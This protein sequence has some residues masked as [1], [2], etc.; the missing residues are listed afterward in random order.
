[1]TKRFTI[2]VVA[3]I[4]LSLICLPCLSSAECA[5][6]HVSHQTTIYHNHGDSGHT[7]MTACKCNDCG[8]L[9]G[10]HPAT[11]ESPLE[12]HTYRYVTDWHGSGFKHYIKYRCRYCN[13]T[14]TV[15]YY[16]TGN[17]CISPLAFDPTYIQ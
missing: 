16:C 3:I 7:H 11:G 15:S 9:L 5:H 12:E 17:P 8:Q 6:A 4:V 14:K 10:C 13:A 2:L 1:M